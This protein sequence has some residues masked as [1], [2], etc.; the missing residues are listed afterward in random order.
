MNQL[1]ANVNNGGS[2]G[3]T[4]LMWAAKR[5]NSYMASNLIDYGSDL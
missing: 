1:K 4:P 2:T 5:D 3:I